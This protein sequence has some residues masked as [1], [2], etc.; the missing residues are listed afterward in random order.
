MATRDY[1]LRADNHQL[2]DNTGRLV[3]VFPFAGEASE[4]ANR[5]N[6]YQAKL[7][8]DKAAKRAGGGGRAAPRGRGW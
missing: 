6:K 5:L 1:P 4:V 2:F 3:G 8:A 7:K